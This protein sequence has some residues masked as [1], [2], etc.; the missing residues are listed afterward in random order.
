MNRN[1]L[2]EQNIKN[3]T[4]K[5]TW[6]NLEY[7]GYKTQINI[8]FQEN[9]EIKNATEELQLIS[10]DYFDNQALFPN[11]NFEIEEGINL[12]SFVITENNVLIMIGENHL[13]QETLYKI[14]Q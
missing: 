5:K 12:S 3:I 10:G 6:S 7:L 2:F 11:K 9:F 1:R 8:F 14:E 4:L 13:E